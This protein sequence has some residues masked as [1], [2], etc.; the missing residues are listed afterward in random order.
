MD[1]FYVLT[2]AAKCSVFNLTEYAWSMLSKK[3]S[4]L[5]LNS[6]FDENSKPLA[7]KSDVGNKEWDMKEKLCLTKLLQ[8][9]GHIKS[10][11]L[12]YPTKA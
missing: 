8:T 4:D 12:I 11:K 2:Y 1:L 5:I 10:R 3:V 7:M 6:K 9:W